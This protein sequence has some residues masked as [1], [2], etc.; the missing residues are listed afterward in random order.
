MAAYSE[1]KGFDIPLNGGGV[2][3]SDWVQSTKVWLADFFTI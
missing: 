2:A 1:K 3:V